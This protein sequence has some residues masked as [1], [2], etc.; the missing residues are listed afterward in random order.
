MSI[1]SFKQRLRGFCDDMGGQIAVETMI[2]LPILLWSLAASYEFFELHRYKSVRQKATYTVGDMIS[3]EQDFLTKTYID[4]TKLLFDS[5]TN[6]NGANQI[7]VSIIKYDGNADKYKISWS[8]VRGTGEFVPLV[9]ADV[10][11]QHGT[12]PI[13]EHGK[14]II[15]IESSSSY[16]PRFNVGLGEHVKISNRVF[17]TIRFAP[18]ICFEGECGA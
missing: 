15:L 3:R 6:D 8:A 9:N 10:A 5:I 12:L 7:R 17:S 14:E 13:L 11:D 18:Q 4:N 1:P 16:D 2:V